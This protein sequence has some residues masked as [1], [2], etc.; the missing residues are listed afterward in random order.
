MCLDGN[1]EEGPWGIDVRKLNVC[2]N[3]CFLVSL[4]SFAIHQTIISISHNDLAKGDRGWFGWGVAKDVLGS[5]FGKKRINVTW[6]F[7]ICA[8]QET[9]A[10]KTYSGK[11]DS[12]VENHPKCC[13]SW[14]TEFTKSCQ[15]YFCSIKMML[16][17]QQSNWFQAVVSLCLNAKQYIFL[18]VWLYKAASVNILY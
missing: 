12:R 11:C 10:T 16:S 1:G 18:L 13:F 9:V 14:Q 5:Y 6:E 2:C 7:Y 3:V 8:S 17:Y 4:T 15:R